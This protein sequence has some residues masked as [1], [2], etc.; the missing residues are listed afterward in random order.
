[1][2]TKYRFQEQQVHQT[3][4]KTVVNY[5][6]MFSELKNYPAQSIVP[7]SCGASSSRSKKAVGHII[8]LAGVEDRSY[9]AARGPA[10][11]AGGGALREKVRF[12]KS[13]N[14]TCH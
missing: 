13:I 1:M 9:V 10:V 7:V 12:V 14:C 3:L 6:A 8:D 2:A 4:V 5:D 11:V